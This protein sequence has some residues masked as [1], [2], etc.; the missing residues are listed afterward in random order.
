MLGLSRNRFGGEFPG[1]IA[2]LSTQ[3]KI[4]TLG[5]NF[6]HGSIPRG[7]GNLVN[8]SAFGVERNNL[9]G[10]VPGEIGKLQKL[11]GLFLNANKFYS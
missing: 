9:G 3:L 2:N 8:L 7:I 5:V 4:L 11:Q 6:I 10:S 1:S